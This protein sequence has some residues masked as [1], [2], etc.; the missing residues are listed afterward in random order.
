MGA[1]AHPM[2][3]TEHQHT[4]HTAPA[5]QAAPCPV[6]ACP[7]SAL[8][9]GAGELQ[10][11]VSQCTHGDTACRQL[12]VGSSCSSCQPPLHGTVQRCGRNELPV[13][14][15][16]EQHPAA[17]VTIPATIMSRVLCTACMHSA[18]T[19]EPSGAH[20]AEVSDR[21]GS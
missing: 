12:A 6:P 2:P 17:S 21:R 19:Q 5:L 9:R 14:N 11:A 15:R 10:E 20:R 8:H 4:G 13:L 7:H 3:R 16:A 18:E 1:S